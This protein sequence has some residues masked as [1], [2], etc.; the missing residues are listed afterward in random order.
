MIIRR[1][2]LWL[3]EVG[4]VGAWALHYGAGWSV[5]LMPLSAIG[6]ATLRR[7]PLWA[8]L[9]WMVAL[10]AGALAGQVWGAV[11]AGVA[12]WRGASPPDP[13]RPAVYERLAVCVAGLAALTFADGALAWTLP[14]A[15]GL[16][17]WAALEVNRDPGAHPAPQIRL[18]G[19][20]A[21]LGA[22]AGIVVLAL[23]AWSPWSGA[24]TLVHWILLEVGHLAGLIQQ[25]I[26]LKAP[27]HHHV[28]HPGTT[29]K[30]RP[31]RKAQGAKVNFLPLTIFLVLLGAALVYL[32]ARA[33]ARLGAPTL[34]RTP[35]V[36]LDRETLDPTR[37]E[38]RFGGRV[39]F[40]RR[41]VQMR[42]RFMARRRQGPLAGETVREWLG[43]V[44]GPNHADHSHLYEE[45]RYGGVVDDAERSR[46]MRQGWPAHAST[47]TRGDARLD[48]GDSPR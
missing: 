16:G 17:L 15:L 26:G 19:V 8:I 25:A 23:V 41:V 46:L 22:G 39:T 33:L 3:L 43:R 28:G 4:W 38:R 24:G 32:A 1:P 44:H 47:D 34:E 5:A 13:D 36:R 21:L 48:K 29:P 45:V 20:L 42:M 35:D 27:A 10:G 40:T 11:L 31:A 6:A 12:M 14:V 30:R 37:L 18:A 2:L 9:F 7:R